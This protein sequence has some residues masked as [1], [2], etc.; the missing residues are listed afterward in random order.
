[1]ATADQMASL[2]NQLTTLTQALQATAHAQIQQGQQQQQPQQQHAPVAAQQIGA[3]RKLIDVRHAKIPAFDGKPHGFDDWAFAF[4]RT[5]RSHSRAAYELMVDVENQVNVDE[6]DLDGAS[7]HDVHGVSAELYDVLCQACSSEGLQV[8]RTVED[9]KGLTAWSKLYRKFNPRTLARAIRLV[10]EVTNPSKVKDIKDAESSLDKWEEM[11]KLLEKDFGE[12]FSET[13]RLGIVAQ[14]M[15]LSV[16]EFIYTCLDD[17]LNY[18][19]VIHKVRAVVSNKV[20]MRDGPAP[21]D[22][23][24]V[25]E[26]E[27]DNGNEECMDEVDALGNMRCHGCGGWGHLRRDCPSKGKG[28]GKGKTGTNYNTGFVGKAR[29]KGKGNGDSFGGKAHGKGFSGQCWNCGETGHRSFEC[30]KG[31]AAVDNE[32]DNVQC[33]ETVWTIGSVGKSND[34]E[35]SRHPAPIETS[36]KFEALSEVEVD[37]VEVNEIGSRDLTRMAQL[38]FNEAD[39]RKPLASAMFVAKAGN[40]IWLD[41]NGGYIENLQT[42]EKMALRVVNDVYV[43]DVQLDDLSEDVITLDSGAGCSVWPRGRHAGKARMT[44]KK[45]GVGMIAANGTP[46][47]HYGQRRIN[48]K[49]VKAEAVFSRRV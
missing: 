38:E 36:N 43:F 16:Q 5:I 28:K 6:T 29:G 47:A 17:K 13:V 49:G 9:M 40:G 21:M 32:E 25:A 4:K 22:V 45:R 18:N 19:E 31:A 11:V 37:E 39:V 3:G 7:P 41:A 15:P 34:Q 24:R 26:N 35:H 2:L 14:M 12:M 48:F 27:I 23:S 1:M 33:L 30:P 46:I 42:G 10:G 44:E 20:A 8:L